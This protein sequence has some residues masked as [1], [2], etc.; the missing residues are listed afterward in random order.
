MVSVFKN[1]FLLSNRHARNLGVSLSGI[2]ANCEQLE[3]IMRMIR[4]ISFLGT[5]KYIFFNYE[6]KGPFIISMVPPLK[7]TK[8]EKLTPFQARLKDSDNYI[9]LERDNII[10]AKSIKVSNN[11]D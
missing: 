2:H 11:I 8:R 7:S 6:R 10:N 9:S 5:L 1:H 4:L 3:S